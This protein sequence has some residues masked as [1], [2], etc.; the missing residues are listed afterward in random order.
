MVGGSLVVLADLVGS[1]VVD[2]VGCGDIRS[3]G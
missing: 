2:L 1:N 3:S